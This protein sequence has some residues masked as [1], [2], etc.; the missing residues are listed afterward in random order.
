M[1]KDGR[2]VTFLK[3]SVGN[4]FW[5]THFSTLYPFCYTSGIFVHT[6]QFLLHIVDKC[7][8][9]K[10][11]RNSKAQSMPVWAGMTMIG[12]HC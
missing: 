10:N 1:Y 11:I 7:K 12:N 5:Q 3:A 6:L 4:E 9:D 2:M 8:F